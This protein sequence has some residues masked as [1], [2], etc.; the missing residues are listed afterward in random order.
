MFNIKLIL[1]IFCFSFKV[2]S[3]ASV[4]DRKRPRNIHTLFDSIIGLRSESWEAGYWYSFC[5]KPFNMF[6]NIEN[7]VFSPKNKLSGGNAQ[8]K[9]NSDLLGFFLLLQ[10][11]LF[12]RENKYKTMSMKVKSNLQQSIVWMS[13]NTIFAKN[14]SIFIQ[15]YFYL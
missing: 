11:F 1:N 13:S 9:Y 8:G 6:L 10:F 2:F 3:K 14:I 12:N 7:G 5:P 15:I 4:N